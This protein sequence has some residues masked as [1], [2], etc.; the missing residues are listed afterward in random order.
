M[1]STNFQL[2]MSWDEMLQLLNREGLLAFIRLHPSEV[3]WSEK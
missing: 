3:I 1:K 2:M